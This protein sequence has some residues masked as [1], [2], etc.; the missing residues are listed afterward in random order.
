MFYSFGLS[1]GQACGRRRTRKLETPWMEVEN[2]NKEGTTLH[3]DQWLSH[4]SYCF[5]IRMQSVN[6]MH[7]VFM[8]WEK[9]PQKTLIYY[10]LLSC[11]SA[12]LAQWENT[13]LHGHSQTTEEQAQMLHRTYRVIPPQWWRVLALMEAV[14]CIYPL[15]PFSTLG[16]THRFESHAL[17]VKRGDVF[18]WWTRL[19]GCVCRGEERFLTA[20]TRAKA[21]I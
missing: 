17:E 16:W 7:I 20:G 11:I 12:W 15:E 3:N 9:T 1:K 2:E 10:M 21:H 13:Y 14:T 18:S 19:G 8:F 4:F 6:R 5:T